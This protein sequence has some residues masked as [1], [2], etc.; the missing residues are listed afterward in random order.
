MQKQEQNLSSLAQE[1]DHRIMMPHVEK[2]SHSRAF[3]S[4]TISLYFPSQF[5][6][7]DRKV[8]AKGRSLKKFANFIGFETKLPLN[9]T[10][11]RYIL[12]RLHRI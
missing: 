5:R 10:T 9:H 12:K 3:C 6:R 1:I 11:D 7:E 8:K 2:K 4:S